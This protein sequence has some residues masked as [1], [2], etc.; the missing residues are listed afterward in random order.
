MTITRSHNRYPT[1]CLLW[2]QHF[3]TSGQGLLINLIH[4]WWPS[5]AKMP[6]FLKATGPLVIPEDAWIVGY[7]DIT[8]I[9][10]MVLVYMLTFGV[11]GWYMLPYVTIYSIHGSYGL[12]YVKSKR[13]DLLGP[14][15]GRNHEPGIHH[16]H[17]QGWSFSCF[18]LTAIRVPRVPKK[19]KG[20]Q[21]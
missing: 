16:A 15:S 21:K 9:G 5:L 14:K 8:Y 11:Y 4:F 6:G 7:H 19:P 17:C 12:E 2:P 10:S 3:I 20:I 13:L 18:F 1:A